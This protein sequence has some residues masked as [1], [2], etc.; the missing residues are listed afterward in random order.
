M[1]D[2]ITGYAIQ[3]RRPAVIGGLF[4]EVFERGAFD[5]SLRE[6]PDVVALWPLARV[7]NGTLQLKPDRLG[8]WYAITPN[9]EAPLAREALATVGDQTLNQVSVGFYSEVEEWDDRGDMPKRL[10]TQARLIELSLVVW[11][12]YGA[13]TSASLLR[14]DADHNRA[15]ARRRMRERQARMEQKIRGI[16]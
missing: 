4:E 2:K 1:A 6:N 5:K 9:P 3:W 11:G 10:I 15:A 14:D 13:D 16:T 12:A 8:L 7:A